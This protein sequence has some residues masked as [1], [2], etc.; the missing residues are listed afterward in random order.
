MIVS[1]RTS[2]LPVTTIEKQLRVSFIIPVRNDAKGLARCLAAVSASDYPSEHIEILVA[3]NGSTDGSAEV[4]RR[5]AAV[6]LVLPGLSVAALRNRTA[7]QATGDLLAFVDAD[8]EIVRT[9]TRSAV[10]AFQ[11]SSVAAVGAPYLPPPDATWVQRV[12]DNLRDHTPGRTDARWIASGNLVV[13]RACFE[14]SMGFDE[15]LVTCEDV[16]LCARLRERGY[17]VL[18]D[19][20]LVSVHHGDPATI[21]ELFRGELWRGQDNLRVSL[22]HPLTLR[23]IPGIVLPLVSLSALAVLAVT[24]ITGSVAWGIAGLVGLGIPVLL[25]AARI[26]YGAPRRSTTHGVAAVAVAATYEIARALALVLRIGHR[27]AAGARPS[28]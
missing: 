15:S 1:A 8:N 2:E 23:D 13:R 14:E 7:R 21:G 26:I 16:D 6:V 11:D 17:R 24:L 3:D 18:S 27:R 10:E 20:K 28:V 19:S 22:R 25:R 9:W 5:F 12:Y 4:G